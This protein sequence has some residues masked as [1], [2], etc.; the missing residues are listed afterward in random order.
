MALLE[1]NDLRTY[2]YTRS[3]VFKAVDGISFDV[4]KGETLGIVGESGSGKSVSSYSLMGLVP[5]P[6]G[7]VVSGTALFDGQDLLKMNSSQLQKIR[8]KRMSMIFQDPMTCLNPF[9]KIGFQLIEP[10]LI[11]DKLSKKEAMKKAEQALEDVGITDVKKRLNAYPHEFS[12]GM[13]QRVMIA[14]ALI[15]E[16]ELLIADEPTTAL[17]VTVQAQI[18]DLINDLQKRKNTAVIFITHDLGVIARVADKVNVM[19][20]G[21]ILESGSADAVF[22]QPTHAYTRA[23]LKSIPSRF[24]KGETL[25]SIEGLP[26]NLSKELPGCRFQY[27]CTQKQKDH[28]WKDARFPEYADLGQGHQVQSCA[29]TAEY[30]KEA[31]K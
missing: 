31:Q 7:K 10:L 9:L 24:E 21:Q 11:H 5:S 14:M 17:D 22:D 23:L 2:F 4:S 8:G 6:P 3:G 26:P 20:A 30:L 16:P 25:Y 28:C 18:L 13:R 19:Y 29:C 12:G 27:R 15:T 1:V